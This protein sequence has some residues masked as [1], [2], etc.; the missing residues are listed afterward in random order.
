MRPPWREEYKIALSQQS[1][2]LYHEATTVI[3]NLF[4]DIAVQTQL[5]D[6]AL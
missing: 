4:Q 6:V 5:F 3:G 1:D 2:L